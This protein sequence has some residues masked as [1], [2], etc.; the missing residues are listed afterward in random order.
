MISRFSKS[1]IVFLVTV[2]IAIFVYVFVVDAHPDS[3]D[4]CVSFSWGYLCKHSATSAPTATPVPTISPTPIVS[5]K[6]LLI[7]DLESITIA[8]ENSCSRYTRNH[9]EH[10]VD[11]NEESQMANELNWV[12]PYSLERITESDLYG[13][14]GTQIEHMVAANEAHYSGMCMRSISERRRF[15]SDPEN[16][17][18]ALPATNRSKSNK[19]LS[20]WMPQHNKCWFA[21]TIVNVKSKYNMTMD[22]KEWDA[23]YNVISRCNNF[24]LYNSTVG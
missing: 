19:D 21:A 14:Q 2:T 4:D 20:E 24:S 3:D 13:S 12:L 18:L 16:L 5:E 8:N 23:A 11:R 15:G 17:T 10:G 22:Q 6:S 7:K 9:Y 1:L